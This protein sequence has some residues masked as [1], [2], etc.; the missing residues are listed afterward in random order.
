[1]HTA[2]TNIGTTVRFATAAGYT[3][4]AIEIRNKGNSLTG[5]KPGCIVKRYEFACQLMPQNT[6]IGKKGLGTF[7]S[8][9]IGAADTYTFYFY[10][11]MISCRNRHFSF[12]IIKLT[13]GGTD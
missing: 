4:T 2:Y 13:G 7:K 12:A 10:N 1:M 6:G 11:G 8:M 5:S 9:E 3:G